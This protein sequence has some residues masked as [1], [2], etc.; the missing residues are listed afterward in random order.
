MKKLIA[1][2]LVLALTAAPVFAGSATPV[3][4]P[5]VIAADTASS[6][7]MDYALIYLLEILVVAALH[8]N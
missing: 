8:A 2:P 6:G 3:M 4:E 1:M 7:G 5:A